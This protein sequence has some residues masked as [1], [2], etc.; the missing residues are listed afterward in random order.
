MVNGIE[1]TT[2]DLMPNTGWWVPKPKPDG[3]TKA[4]LLLASEPH[5]TILIGADLALEVEEALLATLQ[6]NRDIFAWEHEDLPGVPRSIIEH[7]LVVNPEVRPIKQRLRK[8]SQERQVA[9]RDQV[10][11]L[12]KAGVIREVMHPQWLANPVLVKKSNGQ[13]RMCVDY[14]DLNKACPKD[15]F[16]LP[17]IDQLVDAT[18]GCELMSFLDA[19]SGYHQVWM[20]KEDEEKTSFI[21]PCGTFCYVRMQFGLKNAGA[22]FARLVDKTLQNQIGRNVE[23]YVDDIV[24]KSTLAIEHAPNLQETF[25]NLRKSGIKLNPEKCVFGVRAGKLLG[26]LVSKRGIEANPNKIDAILTMEPPTT[27]KGMQRLTGSLAA[28]GRFVSRSAEK[29]LPFFKTLRGSNKFEWTEESQKAFD[30][31][32]AYLASPPLCKARP[33]ESLYSYT[34][35]RHLWLSARS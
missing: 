21:T 10:D 12:L 29:G 7:K 31:L 5:K 11:K 25:D 34:S 24:V 17:R 18:S 20:A 35:R 8:M 22:T 2:Q 1:A 15:N 32:K 26:F 13:W 23:A 4:A 16:P 28:L 19:Y 30:D 9:A 3:E 33:T 6:A 27:I 14:T